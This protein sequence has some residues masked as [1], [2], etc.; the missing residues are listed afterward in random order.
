MACFF[1][2]ATESTVMKR[3]EAFQASGSDVTGFTFRR[4]RNKRTRPP[5]WRN[6]DLGVTAERNYLRR[7][8]KLA[9]GLI[10]VL[11]HWRTLRQA[12]IFY[13]RNID[14]LIIAV[15]AR[16]LTRSRGT[17]VYEVLDIQRIFLGEGRVNKA[18]RWAERALLKRTQLLV[19]SSPD[20]VSRYFEPVQGYAGA[21][22]LLEN[23]VSASP[24]LFEALGSSRTPEQAPPWIIGWFGVLRCAR[25]LEILGLIAERL[26]DKVEI[27]L[28]GVASEDDLPLS[29]IE[30]TCAKHA[31]LSYLGPYLNPDDLPAIYGAVH[32]AWSVDYLDAGTN[33]D[34]LLPNRIYEAGLLGVPALT[35]DGTATARKAVSEDLGWSF[36]EPLEQSVAEFLT[37][38]E[39]AAYDGMRKSASG[40]DR[41]AFV[42]MG[43]TRAMLQRID[44]IGAGSSVSPASV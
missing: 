10:K 32:F 37:T 25:S 7:I 40:K 39:A 31:N 29:E 1:H 6:V 9:L 13:A 4:L 24:R 5:F 44:A 42:D 22:H 35:R 36:V 21:W 12:R 23:K 27:Q 33:S 18:V 19:V 20:F 2:D 28:R 26:G 14:M 34:W 41:S 15:L 8:P 11:T 43:D 38:L 30:S 3:I 16:T 17:V